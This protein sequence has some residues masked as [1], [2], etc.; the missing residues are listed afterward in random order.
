M[1]YDASDNNFKVQSRWICCAM[2]CRGLEGVLYP[3]ILESIISLHSKGIGWRFENSFSVRV[4]VA[5]LYKCRNSNIHIPHSFAEGLLAHDNFF[6]LQRRL[7]YERKGKQSVSVLPLTYLCM[8]L[9][10]TYT[11]SSI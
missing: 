11:Y 1:N 6:V 5:E 10:C 2:T 8:R 3:G 4:F 9:I 7:G